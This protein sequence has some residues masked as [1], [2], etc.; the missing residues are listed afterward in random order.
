[1]P[2]DFCGLYAALRVTLPDPGR[3]RVLHRIDSF[4]HQCVVNGIGIERMLNRRSASHTRFDDGRLVRVLPRLCDLRHGEVLSPKRQ[5]PSRPIVS[6]N[7]SSAHRHDARAVLSI[8]STGVDSGAVK[9][10]KPIPR[11]VELVTQGLLQSLTT[12]VS[13]S[14]A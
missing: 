7:E 2:E 5:I 4:E 9:Q 13:V 14:S 3:S 10:T 1:M 6:E 11:V 12:R 8:H